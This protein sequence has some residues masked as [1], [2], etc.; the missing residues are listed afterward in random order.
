MASTVVDIEAL[1]AQG[2]SLT[3]EFK[4]ERARQLS[5]REIYEAVVCFSNSDNGGVILLGVEDNG[6]VSG[7]QPRHDGTIDPDR[8]RIAIFN[9]TMPKINTRIDLHEIGGLPVV[10]IEVDAHPDVCSM[11]DGRVVRRV[12]NLRGPE[13]VPFYPH[14]YASKFSDLRRIDYSAQLAA[15]LGW[16][17]LDPLEIER[18]R[19]T[20]R[21]LR[22]DQSLLD[23]RDRELI[24]ALQLVETHGDE[25]VPNFAGLLLVGREDV[26]RRV[27][28]GHEVAFQV[29]N[30]LGEISANDWFHSPL[31]KTLELVEDRFS[32]RNPEREVASGLFRVPIPAYDADSFREAVNNSVL[33]RDYSRLGSVFI[34][35][36]ADELTISNPGG[37]MEGITL[38]NLL[39]H[40][41]KPRNPCL[42]QAF[43]RIGLV[44]TTGRGIDRIYL[45]QLRYGRPA[46]DYSRSDGTGVRLVL[47]SS[48]ASAAFTAFAFQEM[49]VADHAMLQQM[50]AINLLLDVRRGTAAEVAAAIQQSETEARAILER[51]IERGWIEARG[52]ARNRTYQLSAGLYRRLGERAGYVRMRG[53]DLIRQESM[54][55]QYVSAY[56]RITRSEVMEL[57][58]VDSR[59]AKHILERLVERNELHM[60][61]RTRGA[62]YV[63][64]ADVR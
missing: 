25:L 32:A 5:D 21:R 50:I 2:E 16:E 27:L 63:R 59:Q 12:M 31:L 46:P 53:Y 47:R 14:E 44:E 36:Q 48:E 13:C 34:Q 20:I 54:V 17:A 23:L 6:E 52:S 9:N 1:I 61:G 56:R 18:L 35:F 49:D 33:H 58:G 43:R 4:G 39:V 60:R 19:Q 22:N 64:P 38:Q 7:A 40:E 37:F 3:V 45:G 42:A 10:A 29:L 8:L 62:Y 11:Q 28:P 26:L 30:P 24:Q 15:G 41:P 57:C 51:L 55:M